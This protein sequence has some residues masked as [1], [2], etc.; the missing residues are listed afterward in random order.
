MMCM[1][2]I[3]EMYIYIYVRESIDYVT[4]LLSLRLH[5]VVVAIHRPLT[6]P[7]LS[8]SIRLRHVLKLVLNPKME[9]LSSSEEIDRNRTVR[10]VRY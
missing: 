9:R 1:V 7:N 5:K 6:V 10:Q 4:L 3:M 2:W 8:Q